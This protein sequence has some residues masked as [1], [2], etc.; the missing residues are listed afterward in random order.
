MID[1]DASEEAFIKKMTNQGVHIFQEN[2]Y[3]Q[4]IHCVIRNSWYSMK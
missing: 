4:K 1:D 2:Q 3:C